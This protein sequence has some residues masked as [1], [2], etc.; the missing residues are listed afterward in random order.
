MSN[1][2]CILPIST[3]LIIIFFNEVNISGLAEI[4]SFGRWIRWKDTQKELMSANI[5][6]VFVDRLWR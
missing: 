1:V 3:G 2:L 4:D 6:T 5:S